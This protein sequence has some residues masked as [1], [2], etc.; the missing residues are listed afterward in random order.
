MSSDTAPKK[1]NAHILKNL[2]ERELRTPDT[3]NLTDRLGSLFKGLKRAHGVFEITGQKENGKYEG[4]VKTVQ[5]PVTDVLW[6]RHINGEQGLGVIPINEQDCCWWGCID[7]DI[8]PAPYDE[9]QSK[10]I[11]L[12]LPLIMVLSKSGGIH[13]FLFLRHNYAASLVQET[14]KIFAE[15][16]GYGGC[17]IFPK[18]VCLKPGETG[19]WLNMPYF[20]DTRK[21][22]GAL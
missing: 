18:Q 13:L 3:S 21:M 6:E 2:N 15:A 22:Y 11:E 4:N 9:I 14:L 17:E 12:G 5:E 7:I 8:Y 1:E 10:V 16:L 19:N 20:G